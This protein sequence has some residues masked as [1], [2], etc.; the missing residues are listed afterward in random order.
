VRATSQMIFIYYNDR[1]F[2]S[3]IL[4]EGGQASPDEE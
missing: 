3:Y 2:A 1:L 4:Q